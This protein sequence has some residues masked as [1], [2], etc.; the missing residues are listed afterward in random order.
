MRAGLGRPEGPGFRLGFIFSSQHKCE[1]K[2]QI[3]QVRVEEMS[4]MA[5]PVSSHCHPNASWDRGHLVLRSNLT[6]T[7]EENGAS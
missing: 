4:V 3:L 1:N 7:E 5:Q 6:V 2:A